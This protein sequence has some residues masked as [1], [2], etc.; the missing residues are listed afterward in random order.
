LY[1]SRSL[2]CPRTFPSSTSGAASRPYGELR[3]RRIA[4]LPPQKTGLA[5]LA[6]VGLQQRLLSS[7]A[8]FVR[9]LKAHRKTLERLVQGEAPPSALAAA[10]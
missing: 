1:L 3:G 2:A 7:T 6:F 10:H 8:A 9:T 4:K 5:K